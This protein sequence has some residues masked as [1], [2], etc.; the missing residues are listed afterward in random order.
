MTTLVTAHRGDRSV[1][2]ENTIPAFRAA[3]A[4]GAD[5]IE[6]D[7]HQSRDGAVVVH[8]D[9]DVGRTTNGSGLV[10]DHD[11]VDLRRLDAGSWFDSSYA[12]L[13]IPLLSDVL[14][15]PFSG[16]WE[17]EVKGLGPTLAV[18]VVEI[19][20]TRGLLSR[21]ELTSPHVPLLLALKR[22]M[23]HVAIGLILTRFPSWMAPRLREQLVL[24]YAD[25]AEAD[26]V[27]VPVDLV[28]GRLISKLH[29]RTVRVHAADVNS[30]A[31]LLR[32]F[33][34]RVDQLSTDLIADALAVR[35]GDAPR[36]PMSS[37]DTPKPQFQP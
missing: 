33:E 14:D 1:A 26:V 21:T 12:G 11:L 15:L 18:S 34:L 25:A 3:I 7:V 13:Q 22:R 5:R 29:A 36:G 4:S 31:E 23:P 37:T 28:N 20:Q 10:S 6:L 2:P 9:Y 17:I 27:H 32:V 19:L 16:G 8:H 30:K 24:S 35:S